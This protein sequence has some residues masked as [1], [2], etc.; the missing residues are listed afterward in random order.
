M[1]STSTEA[2]P[3]VVGTDDGDP[4]TVAD[5]RVQAHARE[6][7]DQQ[8]CTDEYSA[9]IDD[10]SACDGWPNRVWLSR[11]R[12][13]IIGGTT[14]PNLTNEPVSQQAGGALRGLA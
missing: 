7:R 10:T 11:I 9:V 5:V 8:D 2:D 12:L 1:L 3:A 14:K 13:V 4:A 6:K